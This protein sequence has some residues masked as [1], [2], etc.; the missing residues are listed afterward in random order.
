MFGRWHQLVDRPVLQDVVS[1]FV[2]EPVFTSVQVRVSMRIET[3]LQFVSHEVGYVTYPVML[4]TE[5]QL[6]LPSG[7]RA[8]ERSDDGR[9]TRVRG[10]RP[11]QVAR[12]ER[13]GDWKKNP[14]PTGQEVVAHR[15]AVLVFFLAGS[16]CV[17][18][19]LAHFSDLFC[20]VLL[21]LP[22]TSDFTSV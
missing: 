9:R 15:G 8:R 4:N 20:L 16:F 1:C 21:S 19:R 18:S 12:S 17:L 3:E 14:N 5:I 6:H 11:S 7:L 2:W 10:G 22:A 13:H